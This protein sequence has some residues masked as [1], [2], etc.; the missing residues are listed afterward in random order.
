DRAAEDAASHRLSIRRNRDAPN[1]SYTA[2]ADQLF[3]LREVP[4]D[5]LTG[6]RVSGACRDELLA[7]GREGE[8]EDLLVDVGLVGRSVIRAL[9]MQH[10]PGA[11]PEKRDRK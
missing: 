1:P 7:V 8:R 6:L 11:Q 10:R 5:Q 9:G 2:N 4:D 3:A